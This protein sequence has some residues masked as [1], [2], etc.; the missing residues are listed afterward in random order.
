MSIQV[1][2]AGTLTQHHYILT[3]APP[4][5]V[6]SARQFDIV[7]T[8]MCIHVQDGALTLVSLSGRTVRRDGIVGAWR[9]SAWHPSEQ[10][11]AWL[12]E[13]VKEVGFSL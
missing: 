4:T 13:V 9:G 5:V 1:E 6:T 3:D 12:V 10:M 8:E 7:P 11:P 2:L